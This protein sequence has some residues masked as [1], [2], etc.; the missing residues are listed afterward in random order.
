MSL[1]VGL[2]KA[3]FN[4]LLEQTQASKGNLS[5]QIKKL[6]EAGY[7]EVHKHFE[8]NYPKTDC[9]VSPKGLEAFQSYVDGISKYLKPRD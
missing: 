7:I 8:N 2:E 9:K 3:D 1:L 6:K 5:V 4:Y